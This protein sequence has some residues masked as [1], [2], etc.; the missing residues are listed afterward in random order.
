VPLPAQGISEAAFSQATPILTEA[1]I[2]ALQK[3]NMLAALIRADWRIYGKN[4]AAQLLGI[5]PTTL[6]ERMRRLKIKRP[7]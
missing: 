2:I 7:D 5:K 4:G 6:I 3:Q 1:D